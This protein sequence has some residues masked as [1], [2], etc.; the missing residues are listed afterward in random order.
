MSAC[1]Y[2]THL[3][4]SKNCQLSLAYRYVLPLQTT[5]VLGMKLF[6]WDF[7]GLTW[8]GESYNKELGM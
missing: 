4:C 5:P 7:F 3:N 1:P 8:V 2:Q 6:Y